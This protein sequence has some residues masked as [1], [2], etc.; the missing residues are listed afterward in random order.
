MPVVDRERSPPFYLFVTV[1]CVGSYLC[2][3]L[4]VWVLICVG[5]YLCGS[6]FVWV[7]I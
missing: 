6:L 4:F 1:I 5:P 3:S 7:L 2:G